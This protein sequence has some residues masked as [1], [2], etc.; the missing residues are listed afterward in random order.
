MTRLLVSVRTL[1]EALTAAAAG[2]D[3]IDVKEPSRGPLGMADA[4]VRR[5]IGQQLGQQHHLSAAC[6]ELRDWQKTSSDA[7]DDSGWTNYRYAKIGLAGCAAKANWR[8]TWMAWRHALP[9]GVQPVFVCYA[10][11]FHC[12]A[13][14]YDDLRDFAVAAKVRMMLFDTADKRGPSLCQLWQAADILRISQDLRQ[15]GISFVLAGKLALDDVSMLSDYGAAYLGIRGAVC[16]P[17]PASSDVR[18]G[19]L[20]RDKIKSWQL[21][22][23]IGTHGE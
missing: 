1:D 21:A 9:A 22:L 18:S 8:E 19:S 16:D 4:A 17:L 12:D 5:A 13:P 3:L 10:D 2:V 6:G 11:G 20:N 23:K 14:S 15:A 7:R